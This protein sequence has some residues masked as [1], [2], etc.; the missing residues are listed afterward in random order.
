M[1]EAN[2]EYE[3]ATKENRSQESCW[4]KAWAPSSIVPNSPREMRA[5]SQRQQALVQMAQTIREQ[6][7]KLRRL[8]DEIASHLQNISECFEDLTGKPALESLGAALAQ[9]ESEVEKFRAA[10]SLRPK[11]EKDCKRIAR[12]IAS[13]KKKRRQAKNGL[14]L[15]QSQWAAAIA[16]LGLNENTLPNVAN[17]VVA[18]SVE[19]FS[20]LAEAA[21]YAERIEGIEEDAKT[22][23]R[24]SERFLSAVHFEFKSELPQLELAIDELYVSFRKAVADQKILEQLH[25]ER[26]KYEEKRTNS[27]DDAGKLEKL[28]EVLCKEAQCQS[29]EALPDIESRA[30]EARQLR[31]DRDTNQEQLL[32]LAGGGTVDSLIAEAASI[33]ADELPGEFQGLESEIAELEQTRDELNVA[34]GAEKASLARMDYSATAAEAAED[35]QEILARIETESWHYLR[36]RLASAVL[37]EGI[38][39]YRKKN[40]GPVLSRASA[41]FKW[42]TLGSFHALRIG[43]DDDGEQVLEGV[44]PGGP[45]I[46]PAAMSEGTCDQLYLALRLASLENWLERNE[47]LP[48]IVDDILITFD[49]ERATATLEVLSEISQRTQVIFFSHHEHLV[50]L[51]RRSV[52][53]EQLFVHRL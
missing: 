4:A 16:P 49:N 14:T 52:S 43:F 29:P 17:A 26:K 5:W 40:E 3:V 51:A 38:E 10:A 50:D 34:K 27:R 18:Q 32:E 19:F 46:S 22:F 11:L 9:A 37:R 1:G 15:W 33:V 2:N 47:P 30:A 25:S 7:G 20:I 12:I 35:A 23:A 31:H 53:P 24:N 48:L 42:L 41:L 44:R 8:D 6:F 13:G 21:S 28:L 36:L 39:R 45:A